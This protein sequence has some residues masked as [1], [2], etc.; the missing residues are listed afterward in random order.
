[1]KLSKNLY[2][3]SSSQYGLPATERF[4][5]LQCN[6]YMIDCGDSLILVDAGCEIWVD[7]VIEYIKAESLSLSKLKYILLTHEH[8]DHTG[9]CQ[10]WSK[11]FGIKI[12][13]SEATAE[14][15][16]AGGLQTADFLLQRESFTFK[17]DVILKDNEILKI[18]NY[19]VCVIYTP[20]HSP[21]STCYLVEM[22]GKKVMFTG[23]VVLDPSTAFKGTGWAG[24]I[25]FDQKA[26]KTSLEK[27]Y[28]YLPDVVLPGHSLIRFEKGYV[29]I[30]NSLS[31]LTQKMNGDV[32]VVYCL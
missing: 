14:A 32:P 1:M 20:G 15:L 3:I 8:I 27:I 7:R 24:S 10:E 29:W 17:P 28:L 6:I 16:E 23:D 19:S 22:D 21:G 4:A 9:A 2:L 11:R 13:C 26:Y 25:N 30:G 18:G 31:V 5:D 12:A